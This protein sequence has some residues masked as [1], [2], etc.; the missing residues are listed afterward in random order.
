MS[1]R[2]SWLREGGTIPT[3]KGPMLFPL[4]STATSY[5]MPLAEGWNKGVYT[6]SSMIFAW[7][8]D[9]TTIFGGHEKKGAEVKESAILSQES[10]RKRDRSEDFK[11]RTTRIK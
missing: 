10:K 3:E 4:I 7:I 5:D 11:S 8:T 6:M 1:L 9:T 2:L